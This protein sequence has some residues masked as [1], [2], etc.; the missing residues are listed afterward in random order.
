MKNNETALLNLIGEIQDKGVTY[1]LPGEPYTNVG[2]EHLA[3]FL[4]LNDVIVPPVRVGDKIKAAD[5][6][7]YIIIDY[8][9]RKHYCDDTHIRVEENVTVMNS[10][11]A[12]STMR[13]THQYTLEEFATKFPDYVLWYNEDNNNE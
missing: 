11:Y 10:I 12:D 5:G 13:R 1:K 3:D 8:E 2:N 9:Y 4:A 7:E 6:Q